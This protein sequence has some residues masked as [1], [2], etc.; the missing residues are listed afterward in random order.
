MGGKPNF[1]A[2]AD[3]FFSFIPLRPRVLFLQPGTD[4]KWCVT[5]TEPTL[6]PEFVMPATEPASITNP[7]GG[8][9][10]TA[11]KWIGVVYSAEF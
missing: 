8:G 5:S 6:L 1:K 9:I 10:F 2:L 11:D 4:T 3:S 7:R